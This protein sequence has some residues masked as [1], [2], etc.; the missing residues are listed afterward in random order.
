MKLTLIDKISTPYKQVKN[1]LLMT[2]T[3][4]CW[5]YYQVPPITISDNNHEDTES[6]KQQ[7]E[8]LYE[9]LGHY[10]EFKSQL[11]PTDYRLSE[12]LGELA[13]DF[14]D[15]EEDGEY[16][17]KFDFTEIGDT[18]IQ[19]T[20][21]ILKEEL[22]NISEYTMYV[23]VRLKTKFDFNHEELSKN[24]KKGA[25]TVKENIY[26]ILNLEVETTE[27]DFEKYTEIEDEL[28]H[29]LQSIRIERV[30][31]DKLNFLH[32]FSF[33]H[34]LV[35]NLNAE[36]VVIDPSERAGY[37]KFLTDDE[38][39]YL[40]TLPIAGTDELLNGI[41]LFKI[42][43][44]FS[45]S[46]EFYI[47]GR[48]MNKTIVKNKINIVSNRFKE[49][50][51]AMYQNED[52]DDEIVRGKER[53]NTIRNKVNNQNVPMF[54]WMG[55]FVVTGSSLEEVKIK[56]RELKNTMKQQ[57]KVTVVQPLADQLY[58]F[59]KFLQGQNLELT[60]PY[61]LQY[62]THAE[63]AEFSLGLTKQLGSYIGWYLGR[64]TGGQV[65]SRE[66][67][68]ANSR[69]LSLFHSF[70]AHEGLEGAV[71]DSPHI[72]I[73]G[74]TGKGK[75]YLVKLLFFYLIFMKGKVLL[76]DPKSE[77]KERLMTAYYDE[78]VQ[79]NYPEFIEF[80]ERLKFITLN[81][82]HSENRGIL[83]PLNFLVG[84]KASDT[85]FDIF[86]SITSLSDQH[87]E[88]ELRRA[89]DTIVKRKENGDTVGLLHVIDILVKHEDRDISLF[90][91]NIKMKVENSILNLVFGYG[92]NNGVSIKDKATVLEI[93]GLDLPENKTP[94]AEQS[95]S[96]QKSVA[97][98]IALAKFCEEFGKR[99]KH[100]KTTIIFD[101]AWT[102]TTAKGGKKLVK[103]LR[104][105]GRS[106]A[107]QLILVTQSV[108]DV[109]NEDDSGNFGACFFFDES[110][111]R[112]KIL[113]S[114]GLPVN[115]ENMDWLGNMKKGQC[116][117][118]DFY[119]R[120]D[121]ISIDCLFPEW[122]L[123][124]KTTDKSNA[125]RAEKKFS[126]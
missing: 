43:Q 11:L 74:Q 117:F 9:E 45:F 18:Y 91:E 22:G 96:E 109:S 49:T 54:E 94:I 42:A 15:G 121:E 58:L 30:S 24:I 7:L 60:E 36:E 25:G 99:D 72:G 44:Q 55:A 105:V 112:E 33:H 1:N 67:A 107:N 2:K 50:D 46:A 103:S 81:P 29:A 84:A 41:E 28:F 35:K 6:Y 100:E 17:E 124:F 8:V 108:D 115:K 52:E 106:Y 101:E 16:D 21:D 125:G 66:V 12:K 77:F 92:E 63:L 48:P 47:N 76:T 57:Y 83:D 78:R 90:G 53:L 114:A 62:T 113:S 119:G 70:L 39:F 123:A 122:N 19:R 118:R 23:A 95:E 126:R 88:N 34:S 4:Q 104:R 64:I 120:I 98:M 93:E 31:E 27:E 5:A 68:I 102:L 59:Y 51:K 10:P 3:G 86:S 20:Q 87:C 111:E 61:W 75:S 65:S 89:V 79:E 56:A 82:D 97:V 13:K 71:T 85:T 116:L 14:S 69:S 38:E 37:L 26:S 73:T 32:E 110:S 80:V 40:T